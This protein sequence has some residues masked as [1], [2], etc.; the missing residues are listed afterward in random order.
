MCFLFLRNI[1]LVKHKEADCVKCSF[2]CWNLQLSWIY[3]V[4]NQ[5][6]AEMLHKHLLIRESWQKHICYKMA[7]WN[8]WHFEV[9]SSPVCPLFEKLLFCSHSTRPIVVKSILQ[10]FDNDLNKPEPFLCTRQ[11]LVKV[12]TLQAYFTSEP[13]IRGLNQKR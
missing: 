9:T 11:Q 4:S 10:G 5:T 1:S 7:T 3:C 2:H 12:T 13:S 6:S 8:L